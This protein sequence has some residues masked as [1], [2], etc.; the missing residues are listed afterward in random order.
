MTASQITV[1]VLASTKES[2][3]NEDEFEFEGRACISIDDVWQSCGKCLFVNDA[4]AAL[5]TLK[6]IPSCSASSRKDHRNVIFVEKQ[7]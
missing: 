2:E 1:I 5:K 6:V 4:C 7:K 3:M